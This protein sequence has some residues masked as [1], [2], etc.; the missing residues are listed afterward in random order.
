MYL[1]G[2]KKYNRSAEWRR[3]R[4]SALKGADFVVYKRIR[5]S[6]GSSCVCVHQLELVF[7]HTLFMQ[8]QLLFSS[9]LLDTL[10]AFPSPQSTALLK[11]NNVHSMCGN[12]HEVPKNKRRDNPCSTHGLCYVGYPSVDV[13]RRGGCFSLN[14]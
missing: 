7:R 9:S 1:G 2:S 5:E 11:E 10:T 3:E 13:K 14:D 4:R 6:C 12:G 8:R